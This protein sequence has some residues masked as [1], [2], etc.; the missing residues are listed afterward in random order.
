MRAVSVASPTASWTSTTGPVSSRD[1][2]ARAPGS[3]LRMLMPAG[4]CEASDTSRARMRARTRSPIA[5]VELRH[6]ELA[7]VEGERRQLVVGIV[8][9]DARVDHR[10]RLVAAGRRPEVEPPHHVVDVA[11]GEALAVGQHHD[12]VGEPRDL[13]DRM[14]D[15]DDRN[16]ELVAQPL[17]VV[18]DLGLARH[19]ER[20]QRLVHQQDARLREQRAAD[21]DA[22]LFA[23]RQ[24]LAACA[25]A[26]RRGRAARRR[27]PASMKRSAG[28][29]SRW[30]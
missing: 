6:D 7:A 11:D 28:A 19:V 30:P 23:A 29:R 4:R 14:A 17:D 22:L 5:R 12:R 26:A 27:A 2:D 8:R 3:T 24:R 15:V 16:A 13:G 1:R 21:R 20:G 25:A 10:S 18:E 9:G